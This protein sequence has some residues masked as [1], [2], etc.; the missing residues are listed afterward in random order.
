MNSDACLS[1]RV[2]RS[3][4]STY[5]NP[6][7]RK[8]AVTLAIVARVADCSVA[9]VSRALRGS[10]ALPARTIMRIREVADRLGYQGN[11]LVTELMSRMRGAQLQLFRGTLAYLVFGSTRTEWRKHLTYVAF[12]EGACARADELGLT[13]EEFWA[14]DPQMS[15]ARLNKVLHARG[16]KGVIVGPTP[17][18]PQVPLLNWA[19]FAAAKVGVP[20]ADLPLP[21]AVSNQYRGMQVVI[22]RLQ[23]RGYRRLGLVLEAHQNI[24]TSGLWLA[25]LALHQQQLPPSDRVAPLVMRAWAEDTFVRWYRKHRPEV[26]IGLRSEL[27][28][29][30]SRIGQPVPAKV[31]F[32]HL[33]RGTEV[34]DFAGIDQNS[35]AIGAAAVDLVFSRLFANERGIHPAPRQ[36]LVDGIW[37]E[38]A[39]LRPD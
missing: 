32:V 14:D 30:L 21:C 18:L 5:C 27:L 15:P 3:L 20:F 1:I 4:R 10:P 9:T 8:S 35:K 34:G 13:I 36:L 33:D 23:S 12:F 6:M 25:P 38:G 11:P 19:D 31:G 39:T 28:A 37:M 17:G 26:V 22:G 2:A 7:P 29:W 24:K 16:I